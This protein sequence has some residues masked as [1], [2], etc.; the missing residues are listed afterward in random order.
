MDVITF[1]S[2]TKELIPNED[3]IRKKFPDEF[4]VQKF[5]NNYISI[6]NPNSII[7]VEDPISFILINCDY[8]NFSTNPI[9][10]F[11]EPIEI[12][13]F[14]IF[15]DTDLGYIGVNNHTHVI[16]KISYEP[17]AEYLYGDE[18][19]PNFDDIIPIA[20]NKYSFLDALVYWLELHKIVMENDETSIDA[21]SKNEVVNSFLE[22]A[23]IAAGGVEFEFQKV[24]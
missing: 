2:K 19:I 14:T 12:L 9:T 20:K 16:F 10:K 23:I 21:F 18:T 22:K 24:F 11:I 8:S 17:I 15:G 4:F 1:I 7:D 6:K 5:L 13:H 3:K